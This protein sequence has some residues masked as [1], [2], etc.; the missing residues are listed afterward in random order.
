M[1]STQFILLHD[2]E[3]PKLKTRYNIQE[4]LCWF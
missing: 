2:I 4:V 1:P 3:V